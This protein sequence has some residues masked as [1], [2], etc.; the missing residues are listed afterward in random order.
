MYGEAILYEHPKSGR[1]LVVKRV[2]IDILQPHE[3]DSTLRE[4]LALR[5]LKHP[6]IVTYIDSWAATA[7]HGCI[8]LD[9]LPAANAGADHIQALKERICAPQPSG[10]STTVINMATEYVDGGSLDKLIQRNSAAPLEEMLISLWFAQM[11]L[12]VSH[13]HDAGLLHRDLK[14]RLPRTWPAA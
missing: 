13:M 6:N 10:A 9:G 1:R 3:V 11:V 12:A 8:R 4:V 14:V 7:A 5:L 2:P